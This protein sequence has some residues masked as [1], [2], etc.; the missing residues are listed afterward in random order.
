[1]ASATDYAKLF[2]RRKE[3]VGRLSN[4]EKL[5]IAYLDNLRAIA[6]LGVVTVH[7]SQ[8]VLSDADLATDPALRALATLL[9]SGRL[10]VEVFFF[11]SGL[12]LALIYENRNISTRG[13]FLARFLRIWPLWMI[14]SVVWALIYIFEGANT[15]WVLQGLALSS[16]FLLWISPAHYDA[17]IG[18][19]WSIQIE[20]ICYSIFWLLRNRSFEILAAFAIAIN[21]SGAVLAVISALD[22]LSIASAL[23]RLTL[24]TGL[25]FFLLGWVG[26]RIWKK[27]SS[28]TSFTSLRLSNATR[29]SPV[30]V[31]TALLWVLSFLVTPAYYGNPIEAAGFLTLACFL[32]LLVTKTNRFSR[33]IQHLGR[34]SYFLF[35]FH[36]VFL[37]LLAGSN[38]E[39]VQPSVATLPLSVVALVFVIVVTSTL[40]AEVSF[41]VVEKPLMGLAKRK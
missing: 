10:G 11:L 4:S 6:V 13:Y 9:M 16:L 3:V 27:L 7:S 8:I 22:D 41:R 24:Q 40:A 35:F 1:M 37:H 14:F 19:A 28:F 30:S 33:F 2:C 23:R 17:F 32:A 5:N 25:N 29:L 36:F 39:F 34:R 18:G 21:I 15:G 20:V 12:L 31:M 38:F 26:V